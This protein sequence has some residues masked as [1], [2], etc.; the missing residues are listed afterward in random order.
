MNGLVFNAEKHEYLLNGERLPSVTGIIGAVIPGFQASQWHMDRGTATHHGCRLLDEG[1]LD[2][3]SVD[4]EIKPRIEA[5]KAFN[6]TLDINTET[7]AIELPM[8]SSVYRFAG[9]CD[10]IYRNGDGITI[11]DIKSTIEPQVR[12]QLGAYSLLFVAPKVAR[13]AGAVECRADGTY[14]TLWL[15]SRELKRAE[16]QFLAL[17]TVYNFMSEHGLLPKGNKS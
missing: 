15:N 8:A 13:Q 6:S 5:W 10:R 3:T 1:R 4:P 11:I 17:L 14:K 12:L 16:Q 9:T 2:W 7:I